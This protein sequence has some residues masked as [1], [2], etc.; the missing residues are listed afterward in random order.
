[1]KM[2][3]FI[4]I[5]AGLTGRTPMMVL[6]LVDLMRKQGHLPKSPGGHLSTPVNARQAADI[7]IASLTGVGP[8]H[9]CRMINVFRSLKPARRNGFQDG[10]PVLQAVAAAPDLARALVVLIERARDVQEHMIAMVA[11]GYLTTDSQRITELLQLGAVELRLTLQRPVPWCRLELGMIDERGRIAEVASCTWGVDL[12]RFAGGYTGPK[13]VWRKPPINRRERASRT[14]RS[15]NWPRPFV[16]MG[17]RPRGRNGPMRLHELRE[18]R[19]SR[20]AE[21]Q[22]LVTA[23]EGAD[24]DLA[25]NERTR[26][27]A[28]R[29]EVTVL[30]DRIARSEVAAD[31]ERRA[32]AVPVTSEGGIQALERRVSILSVIRSQV[33]GRPLV[34]AEAEF[35]R[36]TERRTGRPAQGI[37]V[38]LAALERPRETRV[39]LT[40][41]APELVPLEHRPDL[42]IQP[43]RNALVARQLGVRVLSGLRGDLSIPKYGTGFSGAWVAENET[44]PESNM[45][46]DSV[47]L[48]PHHVGG[49]TELSRQLIQQSSPDVEALVRD[50][51]AAVIA[52]MIDVA[53]IDGGAEPEEPTGVMRTS[54]VLSGDLSTPSYVEALAMIAALEERNLP[55]PPRWL[56]NP[57]AAAVLR[58]T[59]VNAAGGESFVMMNGRIAEVPATSSALVPNAGGSAGT[60]ILGDWSQVMLGIW[61]ELDILTNPYRGILV[62]KRQ[63]VRASDGN[64]RRCCS[65]A[66]SLCRCRRR[67][68]PGLN[69]ARQ[70]RAS[71]STSRDPSQGPAA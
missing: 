71:D 60:A 59:L 18:Q 69:H 1:M 43:F 13:S 37:Y 50:D 34:G 20:V 63:H 10:P 57:K 11:E 42:Y 15:L 47:T 5:L 40:T 55:N 8:V 70:P 17:R 32:E 31:F 62:S 66:G 64:R 25:D 2:P 3:A 36:E 35:H 14:K 52:E 33:E 9:A 41:S 49:I 12:H 51:L 67:S 22:G 26:F 53:M 58:G 61:S 48:S 39:N 27:D 21:M 24:R 7:L 30:D 68:D 19:A 4:D 46:F 65:S 23:A 54:G 28:L 44:I 38:P 45:T 56:I 16:M 29:G 6:E